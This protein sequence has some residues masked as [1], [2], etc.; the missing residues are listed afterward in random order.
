M[1]FIKSL[2]DLNQHHHPID[3]LGDINGLISGITLYP[4]LY[5]AYTSN[6]L[7]GLSLTTF[8]L[9]LLNSII[10]IAYAIH[11]NLTALL[12]SSCLNALASFGIALILILK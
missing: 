2:F 4:Q 3:Y 5:H 6:S 7:A 1:S 12:V 9:I 10:W 8:V 11:R